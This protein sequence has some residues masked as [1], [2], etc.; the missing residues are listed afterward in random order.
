M[1]RGLFAI[2]SIA[3]G[4]ALLAPSSASAAVTCG[5]VVDMVT[6]DITAGST[7][8]SFDVQG[9]AIRGF[10]GG[11]GGTGVKARKES[12]KVDKSD[13]KARSC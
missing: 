12:A 5:R 7:Q 13:P 1:R 11:I 4:A 10:D 2:C 3:L 6:V 8:A 9:G